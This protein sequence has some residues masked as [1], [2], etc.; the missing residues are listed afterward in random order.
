MAGQITVREATVADGPALAEIERQTPLR[1][2]AAELVIDRGSDY[3][4]AARLMEDATVL[5]AEKDGL[6][7]GVFCAAI[8]LAP[9]GGIERRLLYVHH[10]RILPS[11]QN[12]GLGRRF[13][14]FLGVKFAGQYDSDYFYIAPENLQSQA[15]ARRA[16]NRW[17]V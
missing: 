10:G 5:I 4:A 6:A 11:V 2:G 7:V 9:V 16:Q 8:H 13:S 3:F 17:S 14:N 1:L 15:F 12:E